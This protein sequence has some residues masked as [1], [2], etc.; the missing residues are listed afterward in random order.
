MQLFPFHYTHVTMSSNRI[1]LW[2]PYQF[3]LHFYILI[4]NIQFNVS[5]VNL[6]KKCITIQ[7]FPIS[8]QTKV[9]RSSASLIT[10]IVYQDANAS[11]GINVTTFCIVLPF[12]DTC[13]YCMILC[14][15][16][17]LYSL[18]TKFGL[19]SLIGYHNPYTN[20]FNEDMLNG[21]FEVKW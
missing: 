21:W 10:N 18:F 5:V 17:Q 2:L 9:E 13:M 19:E 3:P 8:C 1:S 15:L 12:K 11:L 14:Y 7:I 4:Q 6:L 20:R 16:H